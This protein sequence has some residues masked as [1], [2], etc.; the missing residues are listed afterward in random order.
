M[1]LAITYDGSK[2]VASGAL[3]LSIKISVFYTLSV[4]EYVEYDFAGG[5]SSS[6]ESYS[7]SYA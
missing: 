2:M 6:K 7:E 1:L 4:S 5:K 3:N